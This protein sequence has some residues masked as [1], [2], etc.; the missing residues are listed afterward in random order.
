MQTHVTNRNLQSLYSVIHMH[1]FE[2][3]HEDMVKGAQFA[4]KTSLSHNAPYLLT[5]LAVGDSPITKNTL[6]TVKENADVNIPA[7]P[8]I[9]DA[10]EFARWLHDLR[11]GKA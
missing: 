3:S 9:E 7:L 10:Y 4:A 2:M 5:P 8:S 6:K 11:G 1:N